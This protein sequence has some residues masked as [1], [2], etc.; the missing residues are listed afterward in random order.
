[1][2]TLLFNFLLFLILLLFSFD[3]YSQ[4]YLTKDTDARLDSIITRYKNG[5]V[6]KYSYTFDSKGNRTGL[7]YEKWRSE[8]VWGDDHWDNEFKAQYTYNADDYLTN[9][10]YLEWIDGSWENSSRVSFTYDLNKNKTSEFYERWETNLWDGYYKKN[11]T[12]DLKGNILTENSETRDGG[13]VKS[14]SKRTFTYNE[15]NQVTSIVSESFNNNIWST[16]NRKTYIYLNKQLASEKY[17]TWTESVWRN[18][19]LKTYTYSKGYLSEDLRQVWN[20]TDWKNSSRNTYEYTENGDISTKI[21]YQWDVKKWEYTVKNSYNYDSFRNNIVE[22]TEKWS[23]DHWVNQ[24]KVIREFDKSKKETLKIDQYWSM[25]ENW[26][27]SSQLYHTFDTNGSRNYTSSQNWLNNKWEKWDTDFLYDSDFYYEFGF[28]ELQGAEIFYYYNN[29]TGIQELKNG[30]NGYLLSQNY[31]NPFNSTTTIAYTIPA[32]SNVSL[33]VRNIL[34]QEVATL[35]NQQQPA[36]HYEINFDA[37]N[38]ESGVY[39]YSLQAGGNTT[40]KKLIL[41]K[42]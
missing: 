13:I 35:V 19:E 25:D 32:S 8:I 28:L 5:Y 14:G 31:P 39:I 1:M 24:H 33:V 4:I 7:L 22:L 40:T 16:N 27:N 6:L 20:E 11:W 41:S 38:L 15:N 26:V 12:Y 2:R 30:H 29:L 36:G 34:G 23:T 17:E 3:G 42:F 21:S 10:L 37:S 18:N 9:C